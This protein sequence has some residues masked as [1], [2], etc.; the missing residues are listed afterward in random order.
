[1]IRG[2]HRKLLF[3]SLTNRYR[4]EKEE[5]GERVLSESARTLFELFWC[6]ANF[7]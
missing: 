6:V 4:Q 7:H 1:M 3:Y 2:Y 5:E